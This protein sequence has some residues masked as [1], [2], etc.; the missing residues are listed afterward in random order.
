MQN[1]GPGSNIRSISS[2]VVGLE[3]HACRRSTYTVMRQGRPVRGHL[4]LAPGPVAPSSIT[5]PALAVTRMLPALS[6][7][8]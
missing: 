3:R 1:R 2:R 8:A 7:S 4:R 6:H 5:R